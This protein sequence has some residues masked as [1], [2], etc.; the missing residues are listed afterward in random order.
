[1]DSYGSTTMVCLVAL[2]IRQQVLRICGFIHH[3]LEVHKLKAS[4]INGCLSGI[5]FHLRSSLMSTD[6][7]SHPSVGA[8][9][10]AAALLERIRAEPILTARKLPFTVSMLKDLVAHETANGSMAGKMI[11]VAAQ[12]GLFCLFRSSEYVGN[13]K[14]GPENKCHAILACDVLFELRQDNG[15]SVWFDATEVRADMWPR[16]LLIKFILRSAKND[17]LR[18]GSVFFFRNLA[19]Y[20]STQI[21]IVQVFFD[22][23]CIA[24]LAK[25]S[26]F[27]AH[28]LRHSNLMC[29]LTYDQMAAAVKRC[30]V[31]FGFRHEDYSTHSLRIGGACTLRAGG[32]SDSMLELLGRW[33][34]VRTALGYTESGLRE[35]DNFQRVLGDES[36]FTVRDVR[37]LH[38]KVG[39]QGQRGP[40]PLGV[41]RVV[42]DNTRG[43]RFADL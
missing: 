24:G 29:L 31:R 21:N 43:V 33:K 19:A 20:S 18:M 30:V 15:E 35:F 25:N 38:A 37:L 8:C 10:S 41:D 5:A 40:V 36:L 27:L 9:K 14:G 13:H 2:G 39:Q 34:N 32:A 7:F 17:R 1:M 28:R 12:L 42:V 23:A 11:A 3:C 22:W 16:V 4:T 26:F 6:A